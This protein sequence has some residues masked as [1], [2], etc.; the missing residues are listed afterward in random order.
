MASG[1]LNLGLGFWFGHWWR[2][3]VA[4]PHSGLC[5]DIYIIDRILDR[6]VLVPFGVLADSDRSIASLGSPLY[7]RNVASHS[8]VGS[9]RKFS[10]APAM[11]MLLPSR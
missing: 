4:N 7:T 3:G 10:D 9:V 8:T 6:A 5:S 1:T 2:D 11:T